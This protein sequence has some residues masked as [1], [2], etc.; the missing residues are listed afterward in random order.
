[1]RNLPTIAKLQRLLEGLLPHAS[2]A[3]EVKPILAI[4]LI[5]HSVNVMQNFHLTLSALDCR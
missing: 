5:Y 2:L 1:M 3:K 4:G